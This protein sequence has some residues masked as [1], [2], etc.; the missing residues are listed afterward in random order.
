[1]SPV[2]QV[3]PALGRL[4]R[5]GSSKRLRP[6][7]WRLQRQGFRHR[8]DLHHIAA[9]SGKQNMIGPAG[10]GREHCS[11]NPSSCFIV[12]AEIPGRQAGAM[13]MEILLS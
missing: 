11:Q 1:M 8:C 4:E 12:T 5:G 2:F 13:G 10:I 3:R 6:N 9:Q 7:R